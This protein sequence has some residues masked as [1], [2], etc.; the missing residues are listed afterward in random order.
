MPDPSRTK[1]RSTESP[2]HR[3]DPSAANGQSAP[4]TDSDTLWKQTLDSLPL[5]VGILDA[6]SGQTLWVNAALRTLLR[7]GMGK[8][9]VNGTSPS[10]Y[11]PGVTQAAWDQ[12]L[13]SLLEGPQ[14]ARATTPQRLQFVHHATRNVAYLEWSVQA[15]GEETPPRHLLLTTEVVSETVMSERLLASAGRAAERARRRAEALMRLSQLVN[16]SLT[17][18]DLLRAVTQEAASFF[19][20]VHAAVLLLK[21]DGLRFEIGYCMGLQTDPAQYLT[22]ENTL[23][24]EA[25]AQKQT[26]VLTHIAGRD[27]Q[28]PLLEDGSRPAALVSSP[29]C[30][31]DHAYGVVEVYFPQPRDIPGDAR[32]LLTAFADQVAL[33]LHKADL[34]D[35]IAAQRRQ[36]QS[37]F[38]NAPVSIVYFDTAGRVMT[39]NADAARRFGRPAEALIGR[40]F[41]D[42]LTDL[43]ADLF[44]TVCAG[45]PFHASHYVHH[46]PGNGEVVSDISLVPV[47][48]KSGAVSGVLMLAFEVTDLVNA[49]QE[50]DVARQAAEDALAETRAMQAQMVQ[51]EKMRAIGE[52]ASGVAHDFNNALMAIL[53]YT[54]LA[55]DSLDDPETIATHLAIIKKASQDAST[56]VQRL[57][58]FARQRGG[59]HGE[60]TDIGMVIK[61]VIDMTR[62]HWKDAAQ[63]EG[64]VY[65]IQTDI[66]ETPRIFAEPSGLREVLINMIQNALHAMP[67]GGTLT[68]AARTRSPQEVEIEVADTGQG[69]TPEV[70]G[71]IFDPFFTTRGV[72]GTGMGL[73]MSWTIIQR[74]G[75]T[76]EVQSTPG[77]G[78]HF[79]IRLPVRQADP[80]TTTQRPATTLPASQGAHVLVVDDEPFVASVLAGILSRN[81]YRVTSAHNAEEALKHLRS[82]KETYHLVLT[83]HGMPGMNGLQ[84]ISEIKHAWPDMPVLLLTGWGESLL[85]THVPETMPDAVLGKPINQ[86]DLL[87]T[88]AQALRDRNTEREKR[89]G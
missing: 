13:K 1:T 32:T 22:S 84:L 11:L 88:L 89:K 45:S 12:S 17:T 40:H 50:A 37:I 43:P 74:H 15:V 60:P 70:A 19:D 52:L 6:Q 83:D 55:E 76:I 5:G 86:S 56:T 27:I 47:R 30:Q 66:Q 67:N 61:D 78:T 80:L 41:R 63:K 4:L 85:E 39:A 79:F 48:D 7:A 75:G 46:L 18:R 2:T 57:Q 10:E 8:E 14:P 64:R 65:T 9:D 58:R 87:D 31:D 68:L 34:Y 72:E 3:R 16:A 51:M 33:A 24:G 35:Q 73:A 62:P 82:E 49:R 44:D 36:L 69:M 59:T 26:L 29:I 21:P 20:S 23:A 42:F 54:E 25:V 38:D 28:T 77:K 53:G 71:R 81:G